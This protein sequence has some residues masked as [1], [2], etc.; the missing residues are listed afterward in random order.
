MDIITIIQVLLLVIKRM[1]KR[2]RPNSKKL[3]KK[4]TSGEETDNLEE[5]SILLGNAA[6]AVPPHTMPGWV[7]STQ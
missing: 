4:H 3:D 5:R 7:N 2:K 1:I 6:R